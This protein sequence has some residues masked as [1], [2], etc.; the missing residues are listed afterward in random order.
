MP[1][2]GRGH[3]ARA[4]SS[5]CFKSGQ[6]TVVRGVIPA[7]DGASRHW[8]TYRF[9]AREGRGRALPGRG[10]PGHHRAQAAEAALRRS[11]ESFRALIEGSPEAIFVHRGGPLRLRQPV[12]AALPGAAAPPSWWARSVL[13]YVHPEDRQHGRGGAGRVPGSE[14]R[15][16]ARELRFLRRR[17]AC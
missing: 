6:P 12:R 15:S 4:R 9:I 14:V 13:E 3:S 17:A 1:D 7:P 8:L 16:G 5:R 11:E 10:V 2:G